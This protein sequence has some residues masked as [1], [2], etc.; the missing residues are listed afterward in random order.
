[1]MHTIAFTPAIDPLGRTAPLDYRAT[2]PLLGV[3]L[4]LRSNSPAVL[5]AAERAFGGWRS[6]DPE[7]IEQREPCVVNLVVQPADRGQSTKHDNGQP[8]PFT[9]RFHSDYF[10]ASDGANVLMAQL[11]RGVAVGFV[12][13]ELVADEARLRHHALDLLALALVARQ[14][15][16]P[17]HAGA[18]VRKGRAVLL[19]GHSMAGKSTLC[20]A[21]LRAGFQL[22]AED[23]VYV[24]MRR[25]MRLWGVPW[26]I[27]LLPDAV[28]RFAELADIPAVL[29]ANG[30][31]KLA[32][33]TA[34]FGVDRPRLHAERAVVCIVERHTGASSALE[35]I[36]PA[37]A[38]ALLSRDLESGFDLHGGTR[39]VA[40]ALVAGG[41]YRLNVG[42]DLAG[43][44]ALL[45]ELTE[46]G[47]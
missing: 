28:E 42:S 16:M 8:I 34:M 10:L 38:V 32:V 18:V 39:A 27:H 12:T 30:K 21:C 46:G 13:P 5:A 22:L 23:V 2:F 7:L 3:P 40:E 37:S 11:D 26:Q 6:V 1:M 36:E 35:P 20:Y 41:V 47:G 43:A 17:V 19:L 24:G 4:E 45:V 15:R 33:E 44:V 14:D 25:G 31:R 29:Q 9:L